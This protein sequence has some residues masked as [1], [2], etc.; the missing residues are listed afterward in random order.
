MKKDKKTISRLAFRLIK[1]NR[2][3]E[4]GAKDGSMIVAQVRKSFPKSKF[5]TGHLSWYLSKYRAQKKKRL[6]LECL[7]QLTKAR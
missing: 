4:K 1:E 6:G 2:L 5:D 3:D 7:H